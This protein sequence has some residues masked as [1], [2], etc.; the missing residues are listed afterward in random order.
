MQTG[1]EQ[2][3]PSEGYHGLKTPTLVSLIALADSLNES[4]DF[5]A[6]RDV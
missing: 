5:L 1:I 2:P 4:L 3:E 6:G